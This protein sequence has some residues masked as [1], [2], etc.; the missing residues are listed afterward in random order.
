M[1]NCDYSDIKNAFD[2]L[3][4]IIWDTYLEKYDLMSSSEHLNA[5]NKYSQYVN[6][7]TMKKESHLFNLS[8]ENFKSL[9]ETN[10]KNILDYCEA[11]KYEK[12]INTSESLKKNK[13]ELHNIQK[14]ICDTLRKELL[15]KENFFKDIIENLK[16]P[17]LLMFKGFIYS[18]LRNKHVIKELDDEKL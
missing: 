2:R 9:L 4:N 16:N 5:F 10:K 15:N 3:F 14:T 8:Y 1:T 7:E 6:N 17:D 11:G 18:S 13:N 12:V